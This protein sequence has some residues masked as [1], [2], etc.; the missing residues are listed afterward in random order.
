MTKKCEEQE[1][2][3]E[4]VMGSPLMQIT[5]LMRALQHATADGRVVVTVGSQPRTSSIKYL[6]LN[7]ASH[8]HD[9]VTQCRWVGVK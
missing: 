5:E 4:V 1:E 8:F 3:G 2:E 7:P 6:L 9:I